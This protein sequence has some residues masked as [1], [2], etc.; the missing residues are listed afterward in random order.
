MSLTI[1]V[2]CLG[3]RHAEHDSTGP[4]VETS[5]ELGRPSGSGQVGD[6]TRIRV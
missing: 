1:A 5:S 3:G 4:K 2:A 6:G